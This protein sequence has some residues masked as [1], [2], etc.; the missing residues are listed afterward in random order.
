MMETKDA[1]VL[2][3]Q[4]ESTQNQDAAKNA[5]ILKAPCVA[6][7]KLKDDEES[8]IAVDLDYSKYQVVRGEIFA[9]IKGPSI[10]FKSNKIS[11]NAACIRRFPNTDY[12][13]I[14]VNSEDK[15][16]V[17][18]P[19]R[20]D[21]KD[22]FVWCSQ[23]NKR[24]SKQ[25]SCKVFFAKIMNLMGWNLDYRYKLLG[26]LVRSAGDLV[27]AFDLTCTETYPIIYK[28][29]EKPKM[30]KQPVFQQEWENQFGVSFEEHQRQLNTSTIKGYKVFSIK[31]NEIVE[32]DKLTR[33]TQRATFATDTLLL[34]ESSEEQTEHKEVL[35]VRN[36]N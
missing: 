1:L 26:K 35:D 24:G 13:Q 4:S 16:L 7:Q 27:F 22:S 3:E 36:E 32:K 11:I 29:G 20:E 23:G 31:D 18:R 28:E 33:E 9:H 17:V 8:I 25:V 10:S 14:L 19:C 6:Y 30:S 12:V 2:G 15:K 34:L 5:D 21:E